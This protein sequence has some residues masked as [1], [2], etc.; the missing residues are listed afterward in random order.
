MNRPLLNPNRRFL[1]IAPES[2]PISPERC[3]R[4]KEASYARA[5]ASPFCG[6]ELPAAS[7]PMRSD[8]LVRAQHGRWTGTRSPF[9][10]N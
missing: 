8:I 4:E 5:H 2:W 3:E 1:E 9:G 7:R 6:L 10:C